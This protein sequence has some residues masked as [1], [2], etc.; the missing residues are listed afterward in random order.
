M[1][2]S[3]INPCRSYSKKSK[4]GLLKVGC[5]FNKSFRENELDPCKDESHNRSNFGLGQRGFPY[6]GHYFKNNNWDEGCNK[7]NLV[8]FHASCIIPPSS[9]LPK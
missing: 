3:Q 1:G 2:R 9:C 5:M 8:K 4:E 7:K 6:P